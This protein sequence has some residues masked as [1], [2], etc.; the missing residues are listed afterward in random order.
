M[1]V[2]HQ[3]LLAEHQ[4]SR[5]RQCGVDSNGRKAVVWNVASPSENRLRSNQEFLHVIGK[6]STIINIILI[7]D[8]LFSLSLSQV[9]ECEIFLSLLVKFLDA[10]KPQWQRVMAI[11]V[12]HSL[13]VQPNLLG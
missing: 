10:D 13:C 4:A 12:I 6:N 1:P 9:T 11:E 5:L 7:R 3:T 8:I 2:G